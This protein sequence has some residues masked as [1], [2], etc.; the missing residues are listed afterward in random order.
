MAQKVDDVV[1]MNEYQYTNPLMEEV[2]DTRSAQTYRHLGTIIILLIITGFFTYREF[3]TH[4]MTLC[5]LFGIITVGCL[6]V[7][8]ATL[9]GTKK[10]ANKAKA[11]FREEYG[12]NGCRVQVMIEASHIRAYRDGKKYADFRRHEILGT[13]ESERFFIFQ[14]YGEVLIPLKKD[15]FEEGSLADCR[16]YMPNQREVH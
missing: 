1:I 13:F 16:S 8:I 14:A 5:I 2:Q 7:L 15:A 4:K 12:T 3:I 10:S 6:V 9:I 11:A